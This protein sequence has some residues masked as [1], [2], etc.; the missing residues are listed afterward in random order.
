MY[1]YT[2]SGRLTTLKTGDFVQI[3]LAKK[4]EYVEAVVFSRV[5]S[6]WRLLPGA[7]VLGARKNDRLQFPYGD[8][9]CNGVLKFLECWGFA[10]DEMEP[11]C[12]RLYRCDHVHPRR[13]FITEL[14]RIKA[15]IWYKKIATIEGIQEAMQTLH[16]KVEGQE[17]QTLAMLSDFLDKRRRIKD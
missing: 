5:G 14:D 3:Q 15:K 9:T 7:E 12:Y 1:L 2:L 13:I 4:S 10:A 16:Y 11:G 6:A 17:E 8:I